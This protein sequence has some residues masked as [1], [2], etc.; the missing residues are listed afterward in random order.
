MKNNT[1]EKIKTNKGFTLVELLVVL[2]LM[3]IL[4]SISIFSAIGWIDWSRFKH[5]EAAAED[6]FYAAQNQLTEL[7]SSGVL[8]DKIYDALWK[9]DESNEYYAKRDMNYIPGNY[10]SSLIL[11]QG[12]GNIITPNGLA[13]LK[14]SDGELYD[15]NKLWKGDFY[16]ESSEWQGDGDSSVNHNY[17]HIKRTILKL[18]VDANRY[19]VYTGENEG[20][21]GKDEEFLFDLIA[22]YI[23]DKSVLNGS[24]SIEFSPESAQ[25]FAVCYSD[26]ADSFSYGL[27][28]ESGVDIRD[29]SLNKR[30]SLMFGY[31]GVDSLTTKIKG[32]SKDVEAYRLEIINGETLSLRLGTTAN[33]FSLLTDSDMKFEIH[34][35]STYDNN[36]YKYDLAMTLVVPKETISNLDTITS[37]SAGINKPQLVDVL[38]K[39]GSSLQKLYSSEDLEE[40][41]EADYKKKTFRVPMW[42][43]D[44]SIYIALDVADIQAQTITY[45][46]AYGILDSSTTEI[47]KAKNRFSNTFSFY[48]FGL[49]DVR[50]IWAEVIID[51]GEGEPAR[52]ISGPEVGSDGSFV[53]H[54]DED[55]KPHGTAVTFADRIDLDEENDSASSYV[56]GIKNGRH[57]YNVRFESDYSHEMESKNKTK[58]NKKNFKLRENIVWD[59]FAAKY[60]FSSYMTGSYS[61]EDASVDK[62]K[63][64]IQL[65][66]DEYDEFD[67]LDG[68]TVKKPGDD[69]SKYPFPAFRMLS[70]EDSIVSDVDD[71]E[72]PFR[73]SNLN[74]SVSANS[75]YG[76]YGKT[77]QNEISTHAYSALNEKGKAGALPLGF[78]AE[79][80]G[81]I[82]NIELDNII[83]K[84][85]EGFPVKTPTQFI[86]TS[87]VGGFV[88]DNFGKVNNLRIDDYNSS[89]ENPP[90]YNSY[91]RGMSDVGGIIGHQYKMATLSS[92]SENKEAI[93]SGCIN[94]A[95]VTGLSYVGGIIGR[96]YL[97]SGD[98]NLYDNVFTV[99]TDGG[100]LFSE[101]NLDSST[102]FK[103]QYLK[104]FSIKNCKNHGDISMDKYFVEYIIDGG[105][106]NLNYRGFYFGGITGAAL[107]SVNSDN[108]SHTYSVDETKNITI[109]DCESYTLYKTSEYTKI[110]KPESEAEKKET[111]RRLRANIVGG[112]VGGIRY[113]YIENCSTTPS[114]EDKYSFVFG[115]RYVGGIAGYSLETEY[116]CG[117][118][119][120]T[121]SSTDHK[122]NVINGT[123]VFGNYAIGGVAGCFGTPET[124]SGGSVVFVQPES[125]FTDKD[126]YDYPVNGRTILGSGYNAIGLR[127]N[128]MVLGRSFMKEQDITGGNPVEIKHEDG[129]SF[130]DMSAARYFYGIGGIAGLL[131]ENI[132]DADFVQ[133]GLTK[134]NYL[135]L[136]EINNINDLTVENLQKNIKD[137][138]F[139]T[140]GVGGLVGQ[141]LAGGN[142]NTKDSTK[143]SSRIDAIIFGRNRV[144]GGVGDTTSYLGGR[145]SMANILPSKIGEQSIG[146]YVLG[147]EN[148]G[149]LVGAYSDNNGGAGY[150]PAINSCY[151]SNDNGDFNN[152][153]KMDKAYHVM[154]YRAVG[155]F[156]GT[157]YKQ[158]SNPSYER[159]S[160]YATINLPEAD[161][162]TVKGSMYVGGIVGLQ[163][164]YNNT[165]DYT[166]YTVSMRYTKVEADC[167][168]GAIAGAIY[169]N[170]DYF[171]LD[172]LTKGSNKIDK[173][174]SDK[175]YITKCKVTAQIGAS[176]VTGLYAL[177]TDESGR[178]V[179]SNNSDSF[180]YNY[181]AY[182]S[183]TDSQVKL[184]SWNGLCNIDYIDDFIYDAE[185]KN[186]TDTEEDILYN[187]ISNI[188]YVF[189]QP[190]SKPEY[191]SDREMDLTTLSQVVQ[192]GTD[193]NR[194]II[195]SEIYCGGLFGYVPDYTFITV[196]NYRNRAE[197]IT[198]KAIKSHEAG[199]LD[200][201]NYSYL[202]GI[203]GRIPLGMTVSGCWNSTA[204]NVPNAGRGYYSG[205]ATFLGG[206]TE[207]NAG[208]IKNTDL[209]NIKDKGKFTIDITSTVHNLGGIAGLN[210]TSDNTSTNPA[211]ITNCV[212]CGD[213]SNKYSGHIVGAVASAA[214]GYS[215]IIGCTNKVGTIEAVDKD[216]EFGI[217]GG[218][219]GYVL[220]FLTSSDNYSVDN[221]QSESIEV[222]LV[223]NI[224]YKN[225]VK[226]VNNSNHCS[227][228]IVYDSQGISVI[229][230]CRNYSNTPYYAITSS[231]EEKTSKNILYCFDGSSADNVNNNITE[232]KSSNGRATGFGMISENLPSSNMNTNFYLGTPSGYPKLDICS[233]SVF[234]ANQYYSTQI[235]TGDYYSDIIGDAYT[236]IDDDVFANPDEAKNKWSPT[237]GSDTDTKKLTFEVVPATESGNYTNVYADIDQFSIVWDNYQKNELWKIYNVKDYTSDEDY[238]TYTSEITLGET[239]TSIANI[240]EE[241]YTNGANK[242]EGYSDGGIGT[243]ISKPAKDQYFFAIYKYMKNEGLVPETIDDSFISNYISYLYTYAYYNNG[244]LMLKYRLLMYDINGHYA[245]TKNINTYM[246]GNDSYY[247]EELFDISSLRTLN[248]KANEGVS[249]FIVNG[250]T[251]SIYKQ[252]GF[253]CDRINKIVVVV[254]ESAPEILG[255]N[256]DVAIR[257]FK[258]IE[259]E[260]A[261]SF[262]MT[263]INQDGEVNLVENPFEGITDLEAL[264]N[265]IKSN[266]VSLTCLN[267]AAD[268]TGLTKQVYL[269]NIP[270]GEMAFSGTTN[271]EGKISYTYDYGKID[272]I[273]KNIMV[274]LFR[275]DL[276]EISDTNGSLDDGN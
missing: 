78:F 72:E 131:A 146:M 136:L 173:R 236:R 250:G 54:S 113:G 124:G 213:K 242:P 232:K 170:G 29:R 180:N 108:T 144:G 162:V 212:I 191:V 41:Y 219:L 56:Y 48:R 151:D 216:G 26:Q 86:Y 132:K 137:S 262:V 147:C 6:I 187:N 27:E 112:I 134:S 105:E 3:S 39:N 21:L 163:E 11:S 102:S 157:Y 24:I 172:K 107:N 2:V 205:A 65:L 230:L 159:K 53:E 249:G 265:A 69:L 148:V 246:V 126:K 197:L 207:V 153:W 125:W 80:Y 90:I 237:S 263:S 240:A 152:K 20:S 193:S 271:A 37:L 60:L 264:I 168:A 45:A 87:K 55:G 145:S 110:L 259:G 49:P 190:E 118:N 121:D 75:F 200:E 101:R 270:F 13:S 227:A 234:A 92:D 254:E 220:P 116:V 63:A 167:F 115:D 269:S 106:T 267:I 244:G 127:N 181:L 81:T 1:F 156:I 188:K 182:S 7:D 169:S 40:V 143:H 33:D 61:S 19:K 253:D 38:Y 209:E 177:N 88:G 58:S 194:N 135:V 221:D 71:N 149:G 129:T 217:A 231:E 73:I 224:N 51:R 122:Y 30:Q 62:D 186:D 31:Y 251:V 123:S 218:I 176:F 43:E 97:P 238:A 275:D 226:T 150:S 93:I 10:D 174:E 109:S 208:I 235:N 206:L 214:G 199:K 272:N 9:S 95:D 5:E 103:K 83:V 70:Y 223:D 210:G 274:S 185:K 67:Y 17:T 14:N 155:G 22:P 59:E 12:S 196:S 138:Y 179:I 52:V 99:G 273:Y 130:V 195:T 25:V 114:N 261:E 248:N 77:V 165:T 257:T 204:P 46:E 18:K 96:I 225:T 178:S 128:A 192:D 16:D 164:G 74:V 183:N 189:G 57:L 111:K 276:S 184:V 266:K 243:Y 50:F 23:S 256:N 239:T 268:E 154:G 76:V 44:E 241:E 117:K 28:G 140:D 222:K 161:P 202:G 247:K 215:S 64:G 211:I 89:S 158:T 228:G 141:A 198:S 245:S 4:L 85:V 139:A 79:N 260:T 171:P 66:A 160:I 100:K 258:W 8:A 42:K 255:G 120:T 142:I 175:G 133:T 201:N 84:G 94:N 98:T 15:W 35:A 229:K 252:D 91:I 104:S 119:A 82:E 233:S 47:T 34:G 36:N 203:T 68:E 32:K 166:L